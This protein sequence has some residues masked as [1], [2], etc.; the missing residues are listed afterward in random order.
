MKGQFRAFT[1]QN[2]LQSAP[3]GAGADT[4]LAAE[5]STSSQAPRSPGTSGWDLGGG[6]AGEQE[7][8]INGNLRNLK[9]AGVTS[10]RGG[11]DLL[12]PHIFGRGRA[13]S[14]KG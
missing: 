4:E 7:R 2:M 11:G 13:G 9:W 10:C 6:R 1:K 14:R 12:A 3:L 5:S 8:R